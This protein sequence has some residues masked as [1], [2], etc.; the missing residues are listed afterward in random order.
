MR[1]R[2]IIMMT[3]MMMRMN[4]TKY[5]GT[6][7]SSLTTLMVTMTITIQD[8]WRLLPSKSLTDRQLLADFTTRVNV[9]SFLSLSHY[10]DII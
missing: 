10:H 6:D 2:K 4:T 1:P 5:I 9:F 3:T 7:K 8:F